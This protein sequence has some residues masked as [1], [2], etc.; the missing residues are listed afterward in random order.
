M[1]ESHALIN[2]DFQQPNTGNYSRVL[3]DR[4]EI[5]EYPPNSHVRIW[6]NNEPYEYESHYHSSVEILFI[7]ENDCIAKLP[8]Q[9]LPLTTGDILIIPPYTMHQISC[10][11]QSRQ[12][13]I[14]MDVE[15]LIHFD[16]YATRD[17]SI[18]DILLCN[19]ESCPQIY[20]IIRNN[21]IDMINAY[22]INENHWQLEVYSS[23]LSMI[24]T[25]GKSGVLNKNVKVQS[26][27]S[28]NKEHYDKFA[29]LL[30][31][32]EVNYAEPISLDSI[33]SYVG[34]SKYHFIRLFKEYTGMTF[35]D[36]L[37][38][39]RIHHAKELLKTNMGITEVAFSCGFNS[40][41]S[42]CRTFKK[43]LGCTPT[44]YRQQEMK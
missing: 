5:I 14:L 33:S 44:D 25:L 34:F 23:Y 29:E 17:S 28:G 13:V 43:V 37:T 39:K 31:Y 3:Q 18:N 1:K 6:Y 41:T 32:I 12:F 38:N 24:S 4:E 22:F 36:Y 27:N 16:I 15:L 11:R 21:I 10:T 30:Q 2:S 42:F 19:K 40:Q 7:Y 35:Y 9:N 20:D 8:T 26:S